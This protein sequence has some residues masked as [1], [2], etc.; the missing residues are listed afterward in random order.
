MATRHNIEAGL[1]VHQVATQ[2][3]EIGWIDQ[4]A[5]REVSPMAEAVVNMAAVLFYQAETG[6][7]SK[8]DF[9]EARA[10]LR[11]AMSLSGSA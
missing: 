1:V 4:D 11:H 7:A 9:L 8:E 2:L 5:A 10:T 6:L 3:M